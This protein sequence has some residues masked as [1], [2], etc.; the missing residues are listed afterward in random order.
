MVSLQSVDYSTEFK[1]CGALRD[2]L[3]EWKE[4]GDQ[5]TSQKMRE[6]NQWLQLWRDIVA[7]YH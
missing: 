1:Q 7:H 5:A 2:H 3:Q 4:S 6:Q